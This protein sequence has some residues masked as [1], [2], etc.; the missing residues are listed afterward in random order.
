MLYWLSHLKVS[1]EV[2]ICSLLLL[3]LSNHRGLENWAKR[4]LG[5]SFWPQEMDDS[6]ETSP[7]D[8]YQIIMSYKTPHEERAIIFSP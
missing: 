7:E 2:I 6:T 1:V 4:D 8:I 3:C 5:R